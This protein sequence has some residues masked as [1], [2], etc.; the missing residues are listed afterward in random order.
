MSEDL[1]DPLRF[2]DLRKRIQSKPSLNKY[3]LEIYKK[4]S[5]CLDR[6]PNEGAAIELGSGAGFVKDVIPAMITSDVIHYDGVDQ[7]IDG[8]K[9]PFAEDSVRFIGMLNVFHHIPDVEAFLREAQRCLKPGGRLLILDQ[10]PG[11]I[12]S[13]IFKNFHHEPFNPK[14]KTWNF[15]SRGPVS[16]ANGALAWIVFNRDVKIFREKFHLLS[17]VRYQPNTPFR[18]WLAGGLKSWSLLPSWA[19]SFATV[20]DDM[21]VRITPAL[22]SFVDIEIKKF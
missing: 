13:F 8:T 17:L 20:V 7:V 15:N 22:G 4:Y 21:V 14:A 5:D 12:S 6:C 1:N 9:M 19:F 3:Y 11:I 16:D 10:H 18:Y 2:F